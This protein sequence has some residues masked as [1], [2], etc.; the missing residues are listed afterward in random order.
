MFIAELGWSA[1]SRR[2]SSM[3]RGRC[4]AKGADVDVQ[5]KSWGLGCSDFWGRTTWQW[6]STMD[7]NG[8]WW[9]WPFLPRYCHT[10]LD[11][12]VLGN[13]FNLTALLHISPGFPDGI[14]GFGSKTDNGKCM[15]DL[16][17]NRLWQRVFNG[18]PRVTPRAKQ[19]TDRVVFHGSDTSPTS[20]ASSP[21]FANQFPHSMTGWCFVFF[22]PFSSEVRHPNWR[23]HIF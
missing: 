9:N 15:A 2:I 10:L 6:S 16:K 22:P 4:G 12:W 20:C 23:T 14:W 8:C 3:P 11:L 5:R 13:I 18:V 17:F 19:P 21:V 7:S 1:I